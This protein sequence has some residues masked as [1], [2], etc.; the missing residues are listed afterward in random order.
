M[1]AIILAAGRGSR[2]G[3]ATESIPKCLLP[4]GGR[5]LL[6]WQTEALHAAGISLIGLVRGYKADLLEAYPLFFFD[7]PDWSGTN[8]VASLF[9]AAE[10]LRQGP[11]IVSYSDIF[12]STQTI[13]ALMLAPGNIVLSYDPNWLSLWSKRFADPLSDAETFRLNG[14]RVCEI[15]KKTQ[16][17]ASIQGQYMGLIKFTPTG[18]NAVEEY[19]GH[20]PTELLNTLDMTSLLSALIESGISIDAIPVSGRWGEVDQK[21]DLELYEHWLLNGA[22]SSSLS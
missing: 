16:D 3:S 6:E 19:C 11:V 10:W 1:K 2:M 13:R 5:P 8:M 9:Q 21:S 22:F 7:N 18:W 4:L 12:Y 20:L 14:E 15:G 17:L